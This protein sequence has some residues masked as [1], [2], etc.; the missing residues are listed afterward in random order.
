MTSKLTRVQVEMV[1][2]RAAE[3]EAAREAR[4]DDEIDPDDLTR[5]GEEV[6]LSAPVMEQ[7][8]AE[9][10]RG[11]LASVPPKPLE[12]LLGAARVWVERH[13]PG[14]PGRVSRALEQFMAEQLMVVHRHHGDRIEWVR[15]EGL[16]P[17]LARSVAFAERYSFGPASRV[18][19]VVC[20][21]GNGTRVSFRIEMGAAQRLGLRSLT[22][23]GMALSGFGLLLGQGVSGLAA[24]LGCAG[25]AGL[26]LSWCWWHERQHLAKLRAQVGVGP[27]RFLDEL[28]RK[29]KVRTPGGAPLVTRSREAS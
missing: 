8:L 13:V 5:L 18:E 7:A 14:R 22:A 17:G 4:A 25:A 24:A 16:F 27:E 21:E 10:N 1:L 26:S 2:R 20:A 19:T 12:R 23:R 9:L 29:R 11:Q 6:G 28:S 15:A 3:L